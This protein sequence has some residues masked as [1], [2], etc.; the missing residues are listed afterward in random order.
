VVDPTGTDVNKGFLKYSNN[1]FSAVVG[2]QR[3][4][5]GVAW[6]QNEQTFDA[7]RLQY[8]RS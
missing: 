4:F 8:W 1:E 7:L 3:F 2:R 6:R 5:C